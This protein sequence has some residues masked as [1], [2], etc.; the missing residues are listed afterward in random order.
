MYPLERSV[1]LR[2]EF[3]PVR[4][5]LISTLKEHYLQIYCFVLRFFKLKAEIACKCLKA[6]NCDVVRDSGSPSFRITC[7]VTLKDIVE[8]L[9]LC[10]C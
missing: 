3:G 10:M 9:C 5:R 4:R 1:Y 6:L 2:N 8:C 7:R